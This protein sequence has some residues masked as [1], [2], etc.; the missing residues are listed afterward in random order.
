MKQKFKEII[1]IIVLIGMALMLMLIA[2]IH[3][4][5]FAMSVCCIILGVVLTLAGWLFKPWMP[6]IGMLMVVF[7]IGLLS[8]VYKCPAEE[9]EVLDEEQCY[10]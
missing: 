2:L 1:D 8:A 3:T 4:L 9:E 7:G 6:F 5:A 10:R